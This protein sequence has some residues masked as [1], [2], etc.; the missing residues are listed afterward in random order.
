MANLGD[1]RREYSKAGMRRET[2]ES[3]PFSQFSLWF[4]QART[5]DLV[6]PNALSLATVSPDGAPTQRMVLLK[7]YDEKGFVFFTNY[8]SRKSGH[9][10]S[11]P[12]ASILF[13]WVSLERQVIIEGACEK[14][15]T[16]ESLHYYISRP[17]GSRIGAWVS[18]Q[19]SVISSRKVIEMKWEE[20]KKKFGE[21]EIPLPDF[22]G[23]YR[24]EP[25]R[26]EFWQG[27]PSRLHDR[28]E[29]RKSSAG[30]W[31]IDRLS[32]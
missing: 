17:R 16:A 19:S 10:S 8:R 4:E 20:M 14:I 5:A 28:F 31:S 1:L 30:I 18:E 25:K 23:G 24:L 21:G 7:A 6:E 15:S 11:N 3:D 2:L 22:W 13:P 29:Y 26:F 9:L 32:P 27:R 12:M